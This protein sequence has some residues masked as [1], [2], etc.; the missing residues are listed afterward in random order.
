M[1]VFQWVT[2]ASSIAVRSLNMM[3]ELAIIATSVLVHF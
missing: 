3:P 1:L 2:I